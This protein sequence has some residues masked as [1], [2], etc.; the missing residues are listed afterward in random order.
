MNIYRYVGSAEQVEFNCLNIKLNLGKNKKIW[1]QSNLDYDFLR[2]VIHTGLLT[3]S[4][5]D[6]GNMFWVKWTLFAWHLYLYLC[7]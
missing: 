5:E 6:K 3:W 4:F 7:T 2:K 1:L